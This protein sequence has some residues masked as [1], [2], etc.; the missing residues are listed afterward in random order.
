MTKDYW[1]GVDIGGTFT[2]IV[3]LNK[4]SGELTVYKHPSSPKNPDQG[5]VEGIKKLLKQENISAHQIKK[6]VHGT[7]VATNAIIENKGSK[8]ALLITK[9]F[10]DILEIRRQDRPHLYNFRVTRPQPLVPRELIFEID[11]RMQYNGEV[12]TELT[13]EELNNIRQWVLVNNIEAVAVCFLHSYRNGK[14]ERMVKAFFKENLPKTFVSLSHEVLSEFKE[15]E[16][17][18]TT[19]ANA[20][21]TPVMKQYV[22]NLNKGLAEM[23]FDK[24]VLIMQSNGGVMT[25]TQAGNH[26]V[27]TLIS[28]P[29]GGVLAGLALSSSD[30]FIT[31]DMGGTSFDVSLVAGSKPRFTMDGEI[32]GYDLRLPRIDVNTIGAGGGSIAWIDNGGALR[33]GPRS[34]GALPGPASY[35]R[36]GVEPTV[37]DAHVVLGRLNPEYLLE[38]G[39]R[40]DRTAAEKAITENIA[41]PLN[42]SLQEAAQGIIDI[43]NAMMVKGIRKVSV[44]RG[45]DPAEFDLISFGGA[46][47]LHAIEL[48]DELGM[49]K[50]IIPYNPGVNSAIGLLRADYRFIK[51]RSLLTILNEDNLLMINDS[52]SELQIK[53]E[54]ELAGEGFSLGDINY[55]F[56]LYLRYA[57][58]GSELE[59]TLSDGII[60]GSVLNNVFDQFAAKHLQEY[61]YVRENEK[62]ELVNVRVT[63]ISEAGVKKLGTANQQIG[64]ENIQ[65]TRQTFFKRKEYTTPIFKRKEIS[66]DQ[67]LE[68]PCIIEQ[69]DSTTV[70][71][72][73]FNVS[74]DEQFNLIVRRK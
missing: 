46:G 6:V 26:A 61:G 3:L 62:I 30:N 2:D 10:K 45:D 27:Q 51:F 18:S 14:H 23:G 72:P 48:A 1:I 31:A 71:P 68:G 63:G 20:Y 42:L 12:L 38:G 50:V 64:K 52:F 29:A 37:T 15:Y 25:S 49:N 69:F 70:V 56:S 73:G 17:A 39:M 58:Q 34:S 22:N 41:H 4:Q 43:V 33:V 32:A 66:I 59:L 36:G 67:V 55:E 47:P 60:K 11:E 8:T 35:G 44:E 9:G 65:V 21:V 40:I 28:G 54:K 53:I 74:V 13:T 7:T 57:G 24:E 16:R 5:A 19:V